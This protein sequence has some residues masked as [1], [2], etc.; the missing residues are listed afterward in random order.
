ML[1]STDI[2]ILNALLKN[3]RTPITKISD[4]LKISNVATQQRI[5]KLEA[6]GIIKSYTTVID[7]TLLDYKTTAYL[8]I[9][10]EKAKDYKIV[11]AELKKIPQILEAHFTTGTYS[12]FAK[13]SA[14]DNIHLMDILSNQVQNI[15]G[16]ARTETFISL[17]EGIYKPMEL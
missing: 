13:I 14:K 3:S 10:L 5:S 7:Y 11:I 16:I 17:N 6:S 9:F 8:G 15:D 4:K 2:K 1:D 12:I